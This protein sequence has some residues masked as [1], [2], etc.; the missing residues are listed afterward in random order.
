MKGVATLIGTIDPGVVG[1]IAWAAAAHAVTLTGALGISVARYRATVP[2]P[3]RWVSRS[4]A[5][6]AFGA[7]LLAAAIRVASPRAAATVVA[8]FGPLLIAGL[9]LVL[10]SVAVSLLERQW[11]IWLAISALGLALLLG[12]APLAFLTSPGGWPA[13]HARLD[14]L[15]TP[16]L[17][18]LLLGRIAAATALC[19]AC[20]LLRA[21]RGGDAQRRTA[22]TA[23]A[24]LATGGAAVGALA[25]WLWLRALGPAPVE[26]LLGEDGRV[27]AAVDAARFA[28]GAFAL[29]SPLTAWLSAS[30]N[31]GPVR[32]TA[33]RVAIVLLLPL[34]VLSVGAAEI[35]RVAFSG[36]W[37]I[38]A[39]GQGWLFANGLTADEAATASRS[40]LGVVWAE[41]GPS[42]PSGS[43]ER[44][45]RILRLACA[46]CHAAAGLA[47]RLDGWP[48]ASIAAAVARLDRLAPASPPFPGDAADARD[49]TLRLALLD[50]RAE[51]APV[52]PPDP[53]RAAAGKALFAATCDHC[54]RE[55]PLARR[56]AGWNEPLAYAVVGRLHR[57]NAA[58]PRFDLGE[59]GKRALAAWVVTMGSAQR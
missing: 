59:E 9:A 45:E 18:P 53:A 49:L 19:G 29:L 20:L 1:L 46:P 12:G 36:G 7:L 35:A 32:L 10:L 55:I 22:V 40:G 27:T 2:P 54:H 58:M 39:P 4:A 47:A 34:A 51:G 43:P 33:R 25:A 26:A 21:P 24:L 38:G 30:P 5:L 23:G 14:A 8:L 11:A 31:A 13:T 48:R 57:M 42:G 16:T 41:V 28:T 50:G 3:V 17:L 52:A 56:V 37:A 15:L 44:G 6:A